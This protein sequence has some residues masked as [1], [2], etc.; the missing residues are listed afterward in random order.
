MDG[1]PSTRHTQCV[2]H[3]DVSVRRS[4]ILDGWKR[5]GECIASW[6]SLGT[7]AELLWPAATGHWWAAVVKRVALKP[8]QSSNADTQPHV[9]LS[10]SEFP[11]LNVIVIIFDAESNVPEFVSNPQCL[12]FFSKIKLEEVARKLT[13]QQIW[14]F[15]WWP[16][17]E[18]AKYQNQ[19]AEFP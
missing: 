13:P 19:M 14:Y 7:I 1:Y 12:L 2:T 4:Y 3:G 10:F 15:L 18:E 9:F 16:K 11:Q 17:C 5:V 6:I 8:R